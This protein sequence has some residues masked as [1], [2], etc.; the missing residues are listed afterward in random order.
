MEMQGNDRL[1]RSRFEHCETLQAE[2]EELG[3][4]KASGDP[5]TR[6]RWI[7]IDK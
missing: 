7:A 6:E 2:A 4:G 5:G 3:V 1:G